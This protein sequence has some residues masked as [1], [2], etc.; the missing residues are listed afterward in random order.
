MPTQTTTPAAELVAQLNATDPRW[1]VGKDFK[2]WVRLDQQLTMLT[3]IMRD[4]VADKDKLEQ[5]LCEHVDSSEALL[6]RK[7]DAQ[8]F[9]SV[10]I[11][12]MRLCQ[13]LGGTKIQ[14]TS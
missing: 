8:T 14:M 12:I 7:S 13:A 4:I 6:T 11:A 10:P 5:R 1:L 3:S 2:D 9:A